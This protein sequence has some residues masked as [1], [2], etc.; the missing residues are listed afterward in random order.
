MMYI[1]SY[2]L[3]VTYTEVSVSDVDVSLT[4][5]KKNT[6]HI[7]FLNTLLQTCMQVY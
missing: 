7:I 4:S 2:Y 1:V 5:R 6:F 3:N